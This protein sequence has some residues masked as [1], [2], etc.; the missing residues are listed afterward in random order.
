M[1]S[2][3]FF[4]PTFQFGGTLPRWE[5]DTIQAECP[6]SGNLVTMELKRSGREQRNGRV[7]PGKRT[8]G[9][10]RQAG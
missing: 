9:Q 10:R 1:P 3:P 7:P 6:D 4:P 5:G 2:S 8:A